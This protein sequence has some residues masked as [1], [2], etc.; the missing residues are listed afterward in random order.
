[1]KISN[2]TRLG[3]LS[4]Y[5]ATASFFCLAKDAELV[6]TSKIVNVKQVPGLNPVPVEKFSQ[7]SKFEIKP[8]ALD[9][10]RDGNDSYQRVTDKIQEHIDTMVKPTL[11]EWDAKSSSATSTRT[12]VIEPKLNALKF[13]SVATRIFAGPFSGSSYV[14]ISVKFYDKDSGQVIA[15]P[16][17]YQRAAAM[18]GAFSFGG[19]DNA[20]LTRV[21]TLFSDYTK[22]NHAA[23]VGGATSV[24][25]KNDDAAADKSA[26]AETQPTTAP[27]TKVE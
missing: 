17:F 27:A 4:I 1:M 10:K 18:S 21:V 2:N 12:L 22:Q 9:A 15:T 16:I 5:M 20:M 11:K 14:I 26:P 25:E 6:D 8:L 24:V 3:L 13:S 7:F 23:A 19:Q